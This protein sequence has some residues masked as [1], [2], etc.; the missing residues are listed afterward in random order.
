[1]TLTQEEEYAAA[2]DEDMKPLDL[3]ADEGDDEER[4][5]GESP[6]AVEA[7]T[8]AVEPGQSGGGEAATPSVAVALNTQ[9]PA[10][11]ETDVEKERQRL[12]S[13][14]GRLKAR[15]A[16]LAAKGKAPSDD[17]ASDKLEDVAENAAAGGNQQLADAANAAAE[18]VE[19]GEISAEDAMKQLAEDFGED[20]VKM[21]TAVVRVAARKEVEPLA[22]TVDEVVGNLNSREAREHFSTIASKHPDFQ[23]IGKS[24]EFASFIDS[25][26]ADQKAEAA[27]IKERGSAGEVIALIDAYKEASKPKQQPAPADTAAAEEDLESME[28]VRSGGVRLPERPKAAPDDFEGAWDQF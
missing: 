25:L 27:R 14:E 17:E 2:F 12:K 19:A 6:K 26:P 23:D 15:E 1:M 3:D 10:A 5:E 11:E 21:V 4:A 24:A 20:F 22:S 28:G 8:P 7:A 16:E 18:A 13:W 9:Q